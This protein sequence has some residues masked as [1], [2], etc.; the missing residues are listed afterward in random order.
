MT[1]YKNIVV[2][3]TAEYS[4]EARQIYDAIV[5]TDEHSN[6]FLTYTKNII[7][8]LKLKNVF[9]EYVLVGPTCPLHRHIRKNKKVIEYFG[10]VVLDK[11]EK[12]T[13]INETDNMDQYKILQANDDIKE[14]VGAIRSGQDI[15]DIKTIKYIP[16]TNKTI[17]DIF[18]KY[19][20]KMTK[21]IDEKSMKEQVDFY[22]KENILGKHIDSK[23]VFAIVFTSKH[24]QNTVDQAYEILRKYRH[25]VIKMY[26]KDV[27]YERLISVDSIE[28]IILVDCPLFEC[29]I[30]LHIPVISLFSM[31]RGID[32]E[33]VGVNYKQNSVEIKLNQRE[34]NSRMSDLV[35]RKTE[36]AEILKQRDFQGVEYK[37]DD[38]DYEIHEG[39][40]GIAS[41]YETEGERNESK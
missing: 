2:A 31:C 22:A 34:L 28:C 21:N 6:A 29:D 14:I 30:P 40:K 17:A 36:V 15:F 26:L 38:C 10:T 32:K 12:V 18:K 13:S 20:I 16:F 7:C 5:D 23:R 27:S 8:P 11:D 33:W 3:F 39:R 35:I 41:S 37:K 1:V 9:D 24:Y 25:S 4:E 19:Q